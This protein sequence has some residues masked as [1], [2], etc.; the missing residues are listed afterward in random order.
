MTTKKIDKELE[1]IKAKKLKA[2]KENKIVKK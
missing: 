2:I 1:A